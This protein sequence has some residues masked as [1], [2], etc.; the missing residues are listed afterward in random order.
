MWRFVRGLPVLM[1][2]NDGIMTGSGI[3]SALN[4]ADEPGQKI[5]NDGE[6]DRIPAP[7][8]EMAAN[9]ERIEA[10]G[11][12]LP[13]LNLA[14]KTNQTVMDGGGDDGI[15]PAEGESADPLEV[16]YFLEAVVTTGEG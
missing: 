14:E 12:L 1:D 8:K 16:S 2:K 6:D 13:A 4:L 7:E 10:G 5:A 3:A 15:F 9:P 11:D